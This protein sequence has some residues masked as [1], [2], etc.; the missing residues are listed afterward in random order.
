MT[1]ILIGFKKEPARALGSKRS[2]KTQ[3]ESKTVPGKA[4]LKASL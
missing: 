2:K 4:I 3:T 1:P